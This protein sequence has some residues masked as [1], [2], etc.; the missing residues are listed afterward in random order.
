[1]NEL[2]DSALILQK[3]VSEWVTEWVSKSLSEKYRNRACIAAKNLL[4]QLIYE[5]SFPHSQ[6]FNEAKLIFVTSDCILRIG[7]CND[8][9]WLDWLESKIDSNT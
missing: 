3:L 6:W 5:Q 4:A 7:S 2:G 9:N 1:M 8:N